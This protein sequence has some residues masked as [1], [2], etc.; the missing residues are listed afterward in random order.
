MSSS[1]RT[2]SKHT[3]SLS[4]SLQATRP[5]TSHRAFHSPFAVLSAASPLETPPAPSSQVSSLYEKQQDH[6]Y[7]S[8]AAGQRRTYYVVSEPDPA[9][10]PYEVPSGAY[11]T[12]APYQNYTATEAPVQRPRSST[13]TSFAHPYLTSAVP[14]NESGVKE[15]S[16]VRYREAP[17]EMSA[18]GGSRGGLGLMDKATTS[19]GARELPSKN[20]QPDQPDVAE[21]NSRLGLDNA[22]KERK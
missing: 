10:T 2:L 11:P 13:S 15:S 22:W 6:V 4:R 12:S 8:S 21:R 19:K 16:S 1:F 17:G 14:Q 7:E 20:P 18:R 3:R 9:N 5:T